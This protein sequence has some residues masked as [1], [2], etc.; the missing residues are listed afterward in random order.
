MPPTAGFLH[1][2]QNL[3]HRTAGPCPYPCPACRAAGVKWALVFVGIGVASGVLE[4]IEAWCFGVMG[5]R[6]A[7]R[8]RALMLRALLRQDI[9]FFDREENSSGSLL[10]GLSADAASVRGAVGDRLGHLATIASCIVASYVIAF[11]SRCSSTTSLSTGPWLQPQS[12]APLTHHQFL[13]PPHPLCPRSWSMTQ[14]VSALLPFLIASQAVLARL[15]FNAQQADRSTLAAADSLASEAVASIKT[16][17]SFGM[18]P[19]LGSLYRR[20]LRRAAPGRS[21]LAAG[22]GFGCSQFILMACS[23][24]AF[25]FGGTQIRSG[26]IDFQQMLT[27]F[28]SIFY[29]AFGLAQV[30]AHAG[31][32][33][34]GHACRGAASKQH[35]MTR[36]SPASTMLGTAAAMLQPDAI[37]PAAWVLGVPFHLPCQAPP[38]TSTPSLPLHSPQAQSAFPD[39]ARAT[40]AVQ[41]AFRIIDLAPAAGDDGGGSSVEVELEGG[42]ELRRV[43]FAY[44]TRPQRLVL[45]GFSLTVPAGTSCALVGGCEDG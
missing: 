1:E 5:H 12:N 2:G 21:A 18:Q 14:V 25:W 32:A 22:L 15:N 9:A 41:R 40:G 29:A 37:L 28:F 10:S 38:P 11:K 36:P 35:N 8:L 44:P 24:L 31:P 16:V 19:A 23:S 3:R 6:L 7:A 42:V 33:A 20:L 26:A 4:V 43:A 30:H 45:K 34:V 17:A 39:L 27:A 13:F